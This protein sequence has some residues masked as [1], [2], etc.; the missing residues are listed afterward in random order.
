MI[1]ARVRD[2]ADGAI[3]VEYPQAGEEE[4]NR[5]AVSLSAFLAA[6]YPAGQGLLDRIP[7]ARTLFCEFDPLR[8][9]HETITR[10]IESAAPAPEG[11]TPA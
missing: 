8:I 6:R 7:G 1:A 5:A 3:L 9:S 11:G 10:A 2:V 4:A